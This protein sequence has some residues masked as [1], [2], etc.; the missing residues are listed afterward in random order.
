MKF[1]TA[2]TILASSLLISPSTASFRSLRFGVSFVA[3]AHR[4][5]ARHNHV[6]VASA[7]FLANSPPAAAASSSTAA[8]FH[9][10]PRRHR[11]LTMATAT[12]PSLSL[13]GGG[14]SSGGSLFSTTATEETLTTSPS[15]PKEIFRADYTPLPFKVSNV[16]MNFDI[17]SGE[18]FVESRLTVVKN[19]NA[20]G[21]DLVLDGEADALTL[22]S[23]TLDDRE[24]VEG[25]DYTIA[26]DTLT[27]P[28]SLLLLPTSASSSI[29]KTRVKIHPETNTQLSGLY[30]S[31]S[32]YCTQCEAMGFRRITYYP[33]R[34][35]N[36][37]VFDS[38]RIEA[39]KDAYPVLLSNGNKLDSGDVGVGINDSR[40]HYAIW[41]DPYPK[42]SYLFC[43]VAGNLGSI[44]SSYTTQPSGRVVHLEIYS[45]HDN[46]SKLG[47]ALESLKKSMKWDEDTFGLEYDLDVYNIV[48]VNDFNMGV[49]SFV[50]ASAFVILLSLYLSVYHLFVTIV[51]RFS[52]SSQT[53]TQKQPIHTLLF[54]YRR[55][56]TKD[57]MYSI[58]HYVWLIRNLRRI[59]IMRGLRVLLVRCLFGCVRLL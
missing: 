45:E 44:S 57:L 11:L 36:M 25:V 7:S 6:D 38:V 35:D 58:R 22:L 10:P 9:H 33:D 40:R 30:K 50:Q 26:G 2:A 19:H 4:R 1:A 8:A 27:I 31:G 49:R 17:R 23:I 18:T 13:R 39:D 46:V 16:S 34:P 56:K 5:G 28:S 55:W 32:V 37:A 53:L 15:P 52:S 12:T 29:L 20:K 51:G 21:G 47:H 24:L 3:T 48:A 14:R 42:P 54:P 43:I 59:L 41:K